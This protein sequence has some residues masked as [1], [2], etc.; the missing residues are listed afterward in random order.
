MAGL[1]EEWRMA[2][3]DCKVQSIRFGVGRGSSTH[4]GTGVHMVYCREDD[5]VHVTREYNKHRPAPCLGVDLH[6]ILLHFPN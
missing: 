3:I 6:C 1:Q 2:E 4:R 5:R